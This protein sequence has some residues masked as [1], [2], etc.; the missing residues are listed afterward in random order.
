MNKIN[1]ITGTNFVINAKRNLLL[2][3][4]TLHSIK[5]IV[6]Y[7]IIVITLGSIETL[8]IILAI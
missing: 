1:S 4:I 7:Q 3:T 2:M 5:N 8:L 6:E